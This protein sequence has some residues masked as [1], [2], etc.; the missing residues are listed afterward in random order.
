MAL[1]PKLIVALIGLSLLA[2]AP[3]VLRRMRSRVL[4]TEPSA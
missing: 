3:V 4:G 2:L 1:T